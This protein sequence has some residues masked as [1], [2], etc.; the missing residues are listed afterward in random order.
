MS[1]R[2]ISSI[3]RRAASTTVQATVEQCYAV[4]VDVVSYPKWIESLQ[5]VEIESTDADGS[6]ARVRF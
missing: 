1:D 4:G 5:L 3:E 6:P 2:T